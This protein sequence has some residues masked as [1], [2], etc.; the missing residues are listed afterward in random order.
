MG[1]NPAGLPPSPHTRPTR[2]SSAQLRS[3][4]VGP[5]SAEFPFFRAQAPPC[6]CWP[7]TDRRVTPTPCLLVSESPC[8]LRDREP[9]QWSRIRR[10]GRRGGGGGGGGRG[11]RCGGEGFFPPPPP[12]AKDLELKDRI[13]TYPFTKS[14]PKII[15]S[16]LG[17]EIESG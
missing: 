12:P 7:S 5:F 15:D 4:L 13:Q 1:Q 10:G 6:G 3:P 17:F 8:E 14:K 16:R 11:R 2:W 9:L